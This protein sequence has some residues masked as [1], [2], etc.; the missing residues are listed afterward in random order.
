MSTPPN[1]ST[2]AFTI[3]S[4]FADELGRLATISV[5][6]PP[7]LAHSAATFFS[8]SALLAAIT[9]LAP[10]AASV[11]AAMAPSAPVAPVTIAVLPWTL[12]SES[13]SLRKSWDMLLLVNWTA[14]ST[15][16][17]HRHRH[18]NRADLV[19]AVDDLAALVRAD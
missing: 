14:R 5:L 18:R 8:P 4:Q 16:L 1:T 15:L 19:A 17:R 6:P 9:T 13:G 2:A 10:A 3:V 12:N 11:F 7:S